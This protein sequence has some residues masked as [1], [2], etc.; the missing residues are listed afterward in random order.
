MLLL[1]RYQDYTLSIKGPLNKAIKT[2]IMPVK[3]SQTM[4]GN[5][6]SHIQRPKDILSV[7]TYPYR[8]EINLRIFD[9]AKLN[10]VVNFFDMAIDQSIVY[11]DEDEVEWNI[12]IINSVL[13][14]NETPQHWDLTLTVQ[15]NIRLQA[16]GLP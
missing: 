6:Y 1:F 9:K 10:E 15:G 13:Q 2:K 16:G 3:V 7:Y 4:S 8:W 12:H 5:L 14:F 11:T